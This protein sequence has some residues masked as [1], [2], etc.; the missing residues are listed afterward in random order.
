MSHHGRPGL[1]D[2]EAAVPSSGLR[3]LHKKSPCPST[4][5]LLCIVLDFCTEALSVHYLGR[6]WL[7]STVKPKV[8]DR[9]IAC[10]SS[11]CG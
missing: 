4:V 9:G 5:R 3:L 11:T 10:N 2:R 8:S 1:R 7:V 6:T